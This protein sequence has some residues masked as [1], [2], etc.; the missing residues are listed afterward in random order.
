MAWKAKVNRHV[1]HILQ[2]TLGGNTNYAKRRP[3]VITA[4]AT[5]TNPRYRV[6]HG[7]ETYGSGAVGIAR[8][9]RSPPR[10]NKYYAG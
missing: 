1:T 6:R 8:I 2:K 10:N 4:I 5:D 9:F 3:A 7:G